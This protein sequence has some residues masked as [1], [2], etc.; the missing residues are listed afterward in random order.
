MSNLSEFIGGGRLCTQE[1]LSSGTFTPS[2]R[3]LALGGVVLV[4]AIGGGASGAGMWLPGGVEGGCSGGDAGRFVEALCT[5]TAPVA[6]T[7]GAGGARASIAYNTV[8]D[9]LPGGDTSFGALVVAKGGVCG[10]SNISSR[11]IATGGRG[12][13]SLGGSSRETG[14]TYYML[15]TRGGQGI[16]GR[17]GGGAA[18]SAVT[19]QAGASKA[20]DGGGDGLH[21]TG[22]VAADING[23]SATPNSGAGGGAVAVQAVAAAFNVKSGAGGTGWLRVTW[24]E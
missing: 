24:F 17:A 19:A 15:D 8:G 23:N 18:A 14:G 13:R 5:V 9:G 4:E 11:S 20:V 21:F 6:V 3:L 22:T 2:T 1:F 12:A 16:N 10:P 7:I